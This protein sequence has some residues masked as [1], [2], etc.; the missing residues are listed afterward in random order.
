MEVAFLQACV[1]M[2]G[3][4]CVFHITPKRMVTNT[5]KKNSVLYRVRTSGYVIMDFRVCHHG[6]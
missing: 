6:L 2:P 1:D 5:L 4:R 3:Q